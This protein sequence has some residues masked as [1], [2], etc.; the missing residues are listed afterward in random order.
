MYVAGHVSHPMGT[1]R[2]HF[3]WRMPLHIFDF[4][5]QIFVL[6]IEIITWLWITLTTLSKLSHHILNNC[7][8]L[9]TKEKWLTRDTGFYES[10]KE[11]I[12]VLRVYMILGDTI[13]K[14]EMFVL[15]LKHSISRFI[16]WSL[17][18]WYHV[19]QWQKFCTETLKNF[20]SN[21]KMASRKI[22]WQFLHMNVFIFISYY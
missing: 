14:L 7:I 9:W 1:P 20:F 16:A 3:C 8:N 15:I 4:V 2:L 17:S 21:V 19:K 10:K 13:S 18:Q 22:F 5:K 12:K 11:I 6:R